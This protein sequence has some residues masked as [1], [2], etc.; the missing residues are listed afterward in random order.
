[1]FVEHH[2]AESD[3]SPRMTLCERICIY[4]LAFKRFSMLSLGEVDTVMR[5]CRNAQ[6][7]RKECRSQRESSSKAVSMDKLPSA[8]QLCISIAYDS[9]RTRHG[10]NL[11]SIICLFFYLVFEGHLSSLKLC[12]PLV[13]EISLTARRRL[14]ENPWNR[15]CHNIQSGLRMI[16]RPQEQFLCSI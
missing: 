15:E 14:A 7:L 5:I 9:P 13:A 10:L 3:G 6:Y 4:W 2:Q 8:S 16:V 12:R 1:M 11:E